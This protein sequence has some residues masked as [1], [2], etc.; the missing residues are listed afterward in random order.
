[1]G[2]KLRGEGDRETYDRFR[3]RA[4]EVLSLPDNLIE[5]D[6]G[7]EMTAERFIRSLFTSIVAERLIWDLPVDREVVE[8]YLLRPVDEIRADQAGVM[9]SVPE[10]PTDAPNDAPNDPAEKFDWDAALAAMKRRHIHS[11]RVVSAKLLEAGKLI[12]LGDVPPEL[13]SQVAIYR[14]ALTK[15]VEN[16]DQIYGEPIPIGE[17]N[18][19]VSV[20]TLGSA[21]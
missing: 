2:D 20:P 16:S 6:S 14:A 17:A 15:F 10:S 1:M 7:G 12:D 21:S 8:A 9:Q 19:H 11:L 3:K 13:A 18:D 4:F 5:L